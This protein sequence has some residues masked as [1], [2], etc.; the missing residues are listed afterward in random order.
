[1]EL[2]VGMGRGV[3]VGGDDDGESRGKGRAK[4]AGTDSIF[5][6]HQ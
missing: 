4:V 5:W 6:T 1:M 2:M 3:V